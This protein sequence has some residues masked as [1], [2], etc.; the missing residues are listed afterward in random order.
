MTEADDRPAG[1]GDET[2]EDLL[3]RIRACRLCAGRLPHGP[4][5]VL[6]AASS[7]RLLLVGQAPGARVHRSGVPWDDRSGERL[8]AWI[9]LEPD[10]FYDTK[11]VAIVPMGFCFPGTAP[12]GGDLPPRP[13]CAP[14]WHRAVLDRLPNIRLTLTIGGYAQARY[15][16]GRRKR[17]MTATV[18]AWREY[19]PGLLPL[20][21]PSW[22]NT[23]WLRRNPWF[24]ADLLPEFRR[25]IAAALELA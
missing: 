23:A 5:P 17:T 8:R 3:R 19:A 9:G 16:A 14:A 22:R 2:L 1:G 24:E 7:A 15:L 20:P 6:R 21:H 12:G 4:R 25:R 13:E 18:R 10:V 11:R